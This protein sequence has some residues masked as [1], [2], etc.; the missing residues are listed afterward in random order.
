MGKHG[1][2]KWT[3]DSFLKHLPVFIPLKSTVDPG[4]HFDFTGLVRV[5]ISN[6]NCTWL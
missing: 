1:F 5:M 6:P 2:N 4:D 3:P